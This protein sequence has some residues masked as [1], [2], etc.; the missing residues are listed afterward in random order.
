MRVWD[1]DIKENWRPTTK[2]QWLWYLE[3]KINYGDWEGLKK[4]D[5]QTHWDELKQ[6][7]DPGKRLMLENYLF[8]H[9]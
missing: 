4:V 5:I 1:Y 2:F 6:R 3:R 8:D 7:L 9:E